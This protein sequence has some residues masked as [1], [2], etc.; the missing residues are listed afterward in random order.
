MSS[1]K[2]SDIWNHFI[3]V[4]NSKYRYC[5]QTISVRSGSTSNLSRHLKAKHVAVEAHNAIT[6]DRSPPIAS[7]STGSGMNDA[8][9]ENNA[10]ASEKSDKGVTLMSTRQTAISNFVDFLRPIATNKS[11]QLIKMIVKEYQLFRNV[12]GTEFRKFVNLLCPGYNLPSRKIISS[13]LI[14][15]LLFNVTKL[16]VENRL[17]AAVAMCTSNYRWMDLYTFKKWNIENKVVAVVSENAS[18]IT[19]V[20]RNGGW[21]HLGC[22]AHALNLVVQTALQKI[23]LTI[24]KVKRIVKLFKRSLHA[25]AKL[26][27]IQELM[28]V[29]QLKLK[30]D[31]VTR[32][33]STYDMLTGIFKI[34]DAVVSTLA[35][36]SHEQVN[37][38][39]PTDWTIVEKV[40][41]LDMFNEVTNEISAEK[42]LS[43]SKII[44]FVETMKQHVGHFNIDCILLPELHEIIQIFTAQLTTRFSTIKDNELIAQ[45][46]PL[47]PRFKKY[48][49]SDTNKADKACASLKKKA[50]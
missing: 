14:P 36:L 40:D 35:L 48:A 49:F 22:F 41:I 23:L 33:N 50:S 34:K 30:Q 12:E 7:T 37:I 6:R 26:H 16:Q 15:E 19:A 44:I 11:K 13:S 43:V 2:R 24:E 1:R 4:D 9:S 18:N 42:N 3:V 32:W 45:A 38:L 28:G 20:I 8:P 31:V 21:R 47:D 29:P 5:S 10:S 46:T 17:R 39:T 27:Q 25:L